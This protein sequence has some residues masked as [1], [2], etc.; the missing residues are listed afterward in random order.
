MKQKTSLKGKEISE[1]LN[2]G[3]LLQGRFLNLY[4][5]SDNETKIAFLVNRSIRGA[6]RRNRVKRRI[7]EAWR[8]SRDGVKKKAH[9]CLVAKE[10]A[11]KAIFS[12]MFKDLQKLTGRN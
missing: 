9:I 5:I 2:R 12:E 4:Y 10:S 3:I 6:V 7:R 1:I 11:E 8:L